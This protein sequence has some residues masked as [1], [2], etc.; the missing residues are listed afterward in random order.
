MVRAELD[1]G[2]L[3]RAT[4]NVRRRLSWDRLYERIHHET[5]LAKDD[6]AGVKVGET[7]HMFVYRE[8]RIGYDDVPIDLD[9][10]QMITFEEGHLITNLH[11]DP[12]FLFWRYD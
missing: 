3:W 9:G 5:A 11:P 7:T 10:D 4:I 12:K 2:G 1:A 6:Y 8:V